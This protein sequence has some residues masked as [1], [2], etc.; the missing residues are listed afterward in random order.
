LQ[1]KQ[2]GTPHK[3]ETPTKR[4]LFAAMAMQ[5]ILS[6]DAEGEWAGIAVAKYAVE[7]ADELIAQLNKYQLQFKNYTVN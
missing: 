4:E 1:F 6:H 7:Q 3:D 5:G 2:L